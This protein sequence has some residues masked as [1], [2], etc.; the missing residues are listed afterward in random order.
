LINGLVFVEPKGQLT[1]MSANRKEDTNSLKQP[2]KIL[3][4]TNADSLGAENGHAFISYSISV[5]E[6]QVEC[7][8]C[9]VAYRAI[10][11]PLDTPNWQ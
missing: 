6:I 11:R 8:S 3:P 7:G 1:I 4:M 9:L 5:L 2:T 10:R